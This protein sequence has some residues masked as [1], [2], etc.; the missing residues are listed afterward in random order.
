MLATFN[1]FPFYVDL[2]G[3]SLDA[4]QIFFGVANQNPETS[5]IQVYWDLA[6]TQPAAQ[7]IRTVS[8]YPVRSGT[9][10][11]VYAATDYSL[12]VRDQ[13]GR[14]IFYVPTSADV[15]SILQLQAQITQ[16]IADLASTADGKGAAL[17][18][19]KLTDG[20]PSTVFGAIAELRTE[21][22]TTNTN[23]ATFVNA[24]NDNL[25]LLVTNLSAG[26]ADMAACFGDSTM[27]GADPANLA[28]QVATPP[29]QQLQN[30][31]NNYF[32]N[33][34][35]TIQNNAI[36]GTTATQM[37]AGTDGSGS[38]FAAKM[39]I[40]SA[41]VVYCNHGV[42]D[43]FGPNATSLVAYRTALLSFINSCR[44]FSKTPILVTPFPCLT[45]GGFGSQAR[46]E[47]TARFAEEMRDLA[48][49]HGVR[50][51]DQQ[52][53]F[54]LYLGQD[55]NLPLATFPDGVHAVQAIYTRSGNNL[56]EAVLGAQAGTFTKPNQRITAS[57]P[58][59]EATG[60]V[61]SPSTTS[62][63]GVIANTGSVSPQTLR[64]AFK[65]D[66]T[67]MDL[68]MAHPI[69]SGGSASITLTLD[70]LTALGM[71]Q[72]I[73]GFVATFWQDAETLI[74]RNIMPGF[75]VLFLTTAATGA[76][77]IHYLRTRTAE[78]PLLLPNAFSAPAER[79]LLS[80][81][82]ELTSAGVDTSFVC[83]DIPM[84]RLVDGYEFEWT[85]TMLVNSGVIVAGNIGSNVGTAAVEKAII[86]GLNAG[87]FFS[88]TEATAPA[89][90]STTVVG[91]ANLSGGSHLYRV[92]VTNAGV[93]TLFVDDASIGT[94]NLLQP[95][96]GGLLG[97]WKNVAGGVLTVTNVN[98]V[99]RL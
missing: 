61:F 44:L 75:H 91:V 85:A 38:T 83:E 57:G 69:W 76:V 5:P 2:N 50:L 95:Y 41:R 32:A 60:Q 70:G 58:F 99:W 29:P 45:I 54:R 98:R 87:G 1:P 81:K 64:L 82:L 56:A 7:P 16:L 63:V 47:V 24:D 42:N 15:N 96:Y 89:T 77:G 25:Q 30:L 14:L 8:G 93:A 9:P 19:E 31:V 34:A 35:L 51:I 36:S 12:T 10:A 53:W 33:T 48:S 20:T 65:V 97:L 66:E 18:G 13:R 37:V 71:S 88:V 4:G 78:K 43:A 22:A 80:P 62:R 94:Y 39:A 23:L 67:G 11:L 92:A 90:Y 27:W 17:I 26:T 55:G 21:L 46:V 68:Y 49:K 28:V 72:S 52:R 59:S 73:A 74:A 3:N 6:G 79:K 40:S 86:F 84:S